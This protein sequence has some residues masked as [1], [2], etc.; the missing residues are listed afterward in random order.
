MSTKI[1]GIVGVVAI[2]IFAAAFVMRTPDTPEPA[3]V[4]EVATSTV[5]EATPAPATTT[6][7]TTTPKPAQK[8]ATTPSP[9]PKP[10]PTPKPTPAP[11]PT[12]TPAP[13]QGY[14]LAQVAVHNSSSSCW[15]AINGKVYDLTSWINQHPGG[16][17]AILSLCGKDGS[18]AYNDQHGGQRRPAN[19]L[20]GF[21]LAPLI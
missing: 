6:A 18:A 16:K 19:E 17:S 7:T 2:G 15:S 12:P 20:A 10:T 3:A 11:T 1:L 4:T 8:P 14:T 13:A 21:Y 5:A 9:A